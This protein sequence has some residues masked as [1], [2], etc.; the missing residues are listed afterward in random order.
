MLL[1]IAD[2]RLFISIHH[3]ILN[4]QFE[5]SWYAENKADDSALDSLDVIYPGNRRY[6]LADRINAVPLAEYAAYKVE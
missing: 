6:P 2:F 1:L 4:A 3:E 5:I